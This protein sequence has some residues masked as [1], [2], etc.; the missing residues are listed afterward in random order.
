MDAFLQIFAT[1]WDTL[2]DF[3]WYYVIAACI[4]M[5]VVLRAMG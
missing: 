4:G 1:V 2:R 3:E 5:F